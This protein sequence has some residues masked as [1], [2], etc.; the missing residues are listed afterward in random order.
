[1]SGGG[2]AFLSSTQSSKV[3]KNLSIAERRGGQSVKYQRA[4]AWPTPQQSRW[5]IAPKLLWKIF[6]TWSIALLIAILYFL[7]A[8]LYRLAA[9]NPALVDEGIVDVLM[10]IG[11]SSSP[12]CKL[13]SEA[14]SST[15][16]W[17]AWVLLAAG[18]VALAY[19]RGRNRLAPFLL[20]ILHT[21]AHAT[22]ALLITALAMMW[23]ANEPRL[24]A[25]IAPLVAAAVAFGLWLVLGHRSAVGKI[26][27]W[28][29]VVAGLLAASAVASLICDSRDFRVLLGYLVSIPLMGFVFGTLVFALYLV[30]V[31]LFGR[32]LRE[33]DA[34]LAEQNWKNFLRMRIDDSSLTVYAIGLENIH[35][36]DV[37]WTEE[38]PEGDRAPEWS[39]RATG[40]Q[41]RAELID[42]V[43]IP[44]SHAG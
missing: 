28:P 35:K 11:S 5:R 10:R 1:V 33:V 40:E 27:W 17:V 19:E 7:L 9:E 31:Q 3:P 37:E 12:V 42:V 24:T 8:Y 41:A 34:A 39:A 14:L 30:I 32:G 13:A 36:R 4:R 38:A 29:L 26:S 21:A 2:G 43:R 15:F 25:L 22:V 6:R 18:M 23:V 16:V 20:G 44:R